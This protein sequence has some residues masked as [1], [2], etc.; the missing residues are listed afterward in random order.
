[1]CYLRSV[2]L[3][4]L[5][6]LLACATASS[7]NQRPGETG[8]AAEGRAQGELR[9]MTYNIKSGTRGLD[10]VAE[11]IRTTRPDIVALQ[12]VDRGSRR[13]GRLDQAAVLAAS[14]GLPYHVHF[15]TRDVSDGAYGIALLSRFPLEAVEQYPLP[16]SPGGEP[17]TLAH[18]VMQVEG[19]EVSVYIT[20]LVHPP[21][22]DRIRLRQSALISSLLARDLRPKILM[23]DFND[24]P[25]STSV[26]LLRRHMRDTFDASGSGWAGTFQ[27]PLPFL[28]AVRI[29]YVM[30]SDSFIPLRSRVPRVEASDHYPVI[31]DVRLK[32]EPPPVG[33]QPENG[34]TAP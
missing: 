31:A 17:R 34:L 12:E 7:S 28:P 24:G 30:A 15:R 21:F 16:M 33:E 29:D 26:R 3:V 23:G 8:E 32:E 27:L 13:A 14:A 22:R 19:R 2:S 10:E 4:L 20:H 6:G 25:D 1:M 9:L 5:A 18:A 11:V